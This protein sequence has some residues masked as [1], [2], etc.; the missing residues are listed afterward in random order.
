M[1]GRPEPRA[2]SAI[3]WVIPVLSVVA[4]PGLV[5]M[6]AERP[7]AARLE[8][9]FALTAMVGIFALVLLAM[10]SRGFKHRLRW[11]LSITAMATLV[12]FQ[13]PTL[14]FVGNIVQQL[15][16]IGL[17]SD[18]T[19][20]LIAIALL[21][22]ATRL[23]EEWLFATI[24]GFGTSVVV[25]VLVLAVLPVVVNGSPV[26]RGEA[27]PDAPDVILLILDGYTRA[28]ILTDQFGADNATFLSDLEQLGFNVAD[29][30]RANY[31]FT[32]ASLT[33][34]F[35]QDYDYQLGRVTDSEHKAMR[36]A[37]SGNPAMFSRF[38]QAGYEIAYT[39]NAWQGSHCGAAVD[40]CIRD[41]FM[42]KV[43]WDAAQ[44]TIFAPIVSNLQVNPFNSIAFEQLESLPSYVSKDRTEGV[45]RLTVAHI[46]MPHPPFLRDAN[47]NYVTSGVRR[48]FTTPSE[49]LI[50][51]R[52][53]FYA[54]QMMCTNR[55][56]IEGLQQILAQRPETVVMITG[57]HGSGSTRLANAASSE[58]SDEA[59]RER[60][61]IFSAYRLPGCENSFYETITPVNGSRMITNCA[62]GDDLQML[63]DQTMWAPAT[64]YGIV[65]DVSDQMSG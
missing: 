7:M 31:S 15:T 40:I 44:I 1:A 23:G 28:D 11:A 12:V 37:L 47:C 54:D 8:L 53:E 13:W 33:A 5:W 29:K 9:G 25:V 56:V 38:R 65:T 26:P 17:L 4:T 49:E 34:M 19:P 52:R 59:I 6:V 27:A 63:L 50:A 39:E 60:M 10:L 20:V 55:K 21:W 2:V 32:Y 46:I 61:S 62:L 58:W 30:A 24:A 43:M 35:D 22:L 45:P 57:D 3:L 41:G 18:T 36:N 51:N 42:Q 16:R 64:G 48:A 14:T